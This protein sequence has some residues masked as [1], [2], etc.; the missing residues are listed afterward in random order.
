MLTMVDGET[1]S[2]EGR[3]ARLDPKTL[4][5]ALEAAAEKIRRA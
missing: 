2:R 3:A 4:L 5:P 1:I